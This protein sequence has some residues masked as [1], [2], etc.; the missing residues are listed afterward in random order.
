MSLTRDELHR[1]VERLPSDRLDD[2]AS[3]L[4]PLFSRTVELSEEP[5]RSFEGY[6]GSFS[7]DPEL[8]EHT[9]DILRRRFRGENGAA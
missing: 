4:T 8:A 7:A 6:Q 2:A 5:V 9:E 1:L 3:A